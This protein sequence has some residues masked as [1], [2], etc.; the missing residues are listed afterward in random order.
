[1]KRFIF[2]FFS[3]LLCSGCMSIERSSTEYVT[4]G[5]IVVPGEQVFIS[6][7]GYY[8][9]GS[10]P[11]F[12]GNETGTGTTFFSDGATLDKTQKYLS[13]LADKEGAAVVHVQPMVHS[14]CSF[15][16]IP[17]FGT[18]FGLFWY[19]EVQLSATLVKLSE[20]N[21]IYHI[22]LKKDQIEEGK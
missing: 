19:K 3:V 5:G 8:L 6:N 17:I 7:Y 10:I 21:E 18:T 2:V 16:A 4:E 12:T 20:T 11:L 15:S 1:M 22:E 9:F 13:E 14:T